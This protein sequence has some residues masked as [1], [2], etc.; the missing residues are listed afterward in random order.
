MNVKDAPAQTFARASEANLS[1]TSEEASPD[2]AFVPSIHDPEEV[3]EV[4][5]TVN[6]QAR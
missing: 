6:E 3:I 1:C 4:F 2:L 5:P